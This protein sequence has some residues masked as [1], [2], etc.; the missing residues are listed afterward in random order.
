MKCAKLIILTVVAIPLLLVLPAWSQGGNPPAS[1]KESGATS[2]H[3][4]TPVEQSG[5]SSGGNVEQ[6]NA[7]MSVEVAQAFG[8]A[9]IGW[10]EKHFADEFTAIHSNG[11]LASKAQEIDNVKTGNLKWATVDVHDQKINVIGDTAVVVRLTSSTGRS[12]EHTS[13]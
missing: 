4:M 7:A 5:K 11:T 10:L 12:E 8:K 9:D 2:G 3:G 1:T 13:E 6:Q